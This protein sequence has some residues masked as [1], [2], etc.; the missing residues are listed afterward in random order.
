MI[1]GTKCKE[2]LNENMGSLL[3]KDGSF[4]FENAWKL[5]K[6]IFPKC[7]DAPFAVFDKDRELVADYEGILGV[8]KEEFQFRLRNRDINPDYEELKELKEYLCKL[9]LKISRQTES[10]KWTIKVLKF[11]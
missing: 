9:R 1:Q 6:K 8:M 2:I 3:T 10:R 7:S 11:A 5:K 4:S